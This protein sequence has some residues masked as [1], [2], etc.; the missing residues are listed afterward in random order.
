MPSTMSGMIIVPFLATT[1]VRNGGLSEEDVALVYL[2]GGVATLISNNVFGRL[3]DRFGHRVVFN[4]IAVFAI[5]PVLAVGSIGPWPMSVILV[6]TTLF[7]ISMGGRWT[8][9]MALVTMSVPGRL[10]GGF[11]SLNSATQALF[12]ALRAG[13]R[14]FKA[15]CD[16]ITNSIAAG[17]VDEIRGQLPEDM[18]TL[19]P[20]MLR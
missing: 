7:T 11:M 9:T 13:C 16:A 4:W 18:K 10:R 8:P 5:L 17:E 2:C 15:V 3:G 20:Q 14:T 12:G 19:F 6:T 1:V